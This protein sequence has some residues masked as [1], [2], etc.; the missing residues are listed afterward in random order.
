[1]KLTA[2]ST[3]SIDTLAAEM[4]ENGI[5][6]KKL[7]E[8]REPSYLSEGEIRFVEYGYEGEPAEKDAEGNIT[9]QSTRFIKLITDKGESCSLSRLQASFFQAEDMTPE[10]LESKMMEVKNGKNAG[11]FFL[12]SNVTANPFLQGNQASAMLKLVNKTFVCKQIKGVQSVYK[13][14]GYW[15]PAE[16]VTKPVTLFA[17]TQK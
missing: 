2:I 15:T 12:P 10:A 17:L 5:S 11:S 6:S 3:K 14:D 7:G 13:E 9:K 4:L 1:M 16:V 8:A